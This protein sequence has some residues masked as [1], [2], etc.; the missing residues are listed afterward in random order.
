MTALAQRLR[1]TI[2]LTG[3]LSLAQ[4]MTESLWHPSE[5]Y[6]A[7]SEVLGA[8][9]DFVT[10]PEISQMFGELIGVWC[11]AVWQQMDR[12]R[13]FLLVELG[14]GRGSLI[15][16][17]LRAVRGL[18]DF[19]QAA[20]LHL[21]EA[22]PKLRARQ[23][24][25]LAGQPAS[26][27][28]DLAGLPD[29]PAIVIV[30]EFFDALPIVQLEKTPLGWHE[31]LVDFDPA[32]GGFQFV[33]ALEPSP[34]AAL[35]PPKLADAPAGSLIELSPAGLTLAATI[36]GRLA[37]QGGAALVIDYGPDES[38]LGPTL[39]ALRRHAR[40]DPLAEPGTADLT[41]HVD[42]ASLA[43]AAREAGALV[44]GPVPQGLF[45]ERLGIRTRAERLVASASRAQ[46]GSIRSALRR[47]IDPGEMG[48]LF[49][50]LAMT[51]PDLPIPIGFGSSP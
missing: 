50:A 14:P 19:L 31:R 9:G 1:R 21:V 46:A 26:W 28:E 39:Q 22:S 34:K 4:F 29:G 44:H 40:H 17:L 10:G 37:H 15:A 20:K 13:P 27:H 42:F 7:R 51:H 36:G 48:T 45:L 38:R 35:L 6:Y 43:R 11:V 2:E 8:A 24:A 18:P 25:A 23:A 30:N 5:G 49:K 12:P 16:D 3:P 47:L 41:A 32:S 33:R